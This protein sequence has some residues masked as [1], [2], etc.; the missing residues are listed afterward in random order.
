MT[1]NLM[2]NGSRA[3]HPTKRVSV[4]PAVLFTTAVVL[5]AIVV[6][7]RSRREAAA[8]EARTRRRL[9]PRPVSA[10]T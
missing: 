5:A 10:G 9:M 4:V 8:L 1:R 2:A 6:R 3:M 7:A